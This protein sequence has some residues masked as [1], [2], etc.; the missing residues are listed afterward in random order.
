[1]SD[2]NDQ[3]TQLTMAI[4]A[5]TR[6][7]C[8]PPIP[9]HTLSYQVSEIV[10]FRMPIKD[11]P[12]T[13]KGMWQL[14]QTFG[15]YL[16]RTID[17]GQSLALGMIMGNLYQRNSGPIDLSEV[18]TCQISSL[19]ILSFRERYGK[20]KRVTMTPISNMIR[21]AMPFI[22]IQTVNS[23]L[24]ISFL[25]PAPII[26]LSILENLRNGTMNNLRQMMD[27]IED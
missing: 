9:N 15:Q 27:V 5:D 3:S 2:A 17:A 14:A 18:P 25:G 4:A 10:A 19:G 22:F 24:T 1:M 6:R 12:T 13:S 16:K 7:R 23:I 11:T 26:P 20:W 8:I 21:T